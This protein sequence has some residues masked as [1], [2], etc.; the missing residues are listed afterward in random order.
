M[1]CI[2]FCLDHFFRTNL[3]CSAIPLYHNRVPNDLENFE[4]L[5][6]LKK[7]RGNINKILYNKSGKVRVFFGKFKFISSTFKLTRIFQPLICFYSDP[8]QQ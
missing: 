8:I 3:V 1:T 5:T 2:K 7:I 6:A 4:K